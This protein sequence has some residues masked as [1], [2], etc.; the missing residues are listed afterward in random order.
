MIQ[1][2][3]D[4]TTRRV[5]VT[6]LGVITSLGL[7]VPTFWENLL[8]GRSGV[9]DITSFDVS[10]YTT[11][12][13]AEIRDFD[14]SNFMERKE[15][16][17]MDRFA[18]FAV[19]A[20]RGAIEQSGLR[21]E[22]ELSERVGVLIG[23]GIGGIL[24]IEEQYRVLLERGPARV[25]PFLIP[26]LI[27]DMAAGQVSIILGAKGPNSAVV[28]ACATGC[29][30]IGDA[31]HIILRGDADAMIAGGAE[32][33]ISALGLGGFCAARALSTRN[34]DPERASRP[35]DA[36]R[37]GFVMGEGAGVVVL[38]ELEFALARGATP[39]AEVVGYGM[40]GD[41][42]HVTQPAPEGEGAARAMRMALRSAGMAPEDIDHIN[43]HGTST[44]P[45][46]RLET[47]AI[48][49]VF[50]E[51]ADR[52]AVS[53]TKSM[54]GHLL[55]AAG[56][57]EAIACCLAVR[58]QVVPPTINYT[59]PDPDCDLDYVPNHA[60]PMQVRA[61]MSNSFGFG[62]HNATVIVARV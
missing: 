33:G 37:D 13:A 44:Q 2:G 1:G 48:R 9:T 43:A 61:A 49:T 38:E 17:R 54:T 10:A 8:A 56:A 4:P 45:N 52:L 18:Q 24:T 39:I 15:A 30:A 35:F 31:A 55:G 53:S 26:M 29:H 11:R 3:P 27:G 41:A 12:I 23:S 40:T 7:T 16:K 6:G 62:G 47:I 21:I 36:E 50:G 58:D 51:H 25:S 19:A 46:D 22:G 20:A 60:R 42:F 14:A 32:A 28:T 59:T 5:V 57:V 34:D